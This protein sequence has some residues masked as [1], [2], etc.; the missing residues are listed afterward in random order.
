M[1][2]N[3]MAVYFQQKYFKN[4]LILSYFIP[5]NVNLLIRM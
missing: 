5:L 1:D 3:F 2:L 4:T